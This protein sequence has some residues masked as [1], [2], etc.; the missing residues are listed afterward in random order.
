MIMYSVIIPN[1][2]KKGTELLER[3]IQSIPDR[4]DVEVIVVDNSLQPINNQLFIDRKN[5]IVL[6]SDH[7]RGAGGARNVGIENAHGK[8]LIFMDADD[9]FTENAFIFFDKYKNSDDDIIFFEV[10]SAYSE[11]GELADRH[12]PFC[13]MIEDFLLSGMEE[14]LR[15]N[16]C[17][18]WG[19]MIRHSMVSDN[20]IFFEEIPASN[21]VMFALNAGLK[22]SKIDADRNVV[23]CVTVTNGSITRTN[24]IENIESIFNVIIRKNLLLKKLGYKVRYSVMYQIY[25]S[26]KFGFMPCFKLLSKAFITG[27]LF[28]GYRNWIKTILRINRRK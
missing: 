2:S 1:F 6:F 9:Y 14:S 21:D 5:T 20:Q 11:S 26:S 16:H 17:V 7:D 24:S 23:Y 12:Y 15:L 19:K 8:W 27:N 22:A 18:P 13:G 4:E 10:T 25:R 28:N 3:S